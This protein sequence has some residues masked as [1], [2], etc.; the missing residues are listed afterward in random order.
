MVPPVSAR[1]SAFSITAPTESSTYA[2]A[3]A[4]IANEM[5]SLAATQ[6]YRISPQRVV[7]PSAIPVSVVAKLAHG[8]TVISK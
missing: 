2:K 5:I 4:R 7:S 8:S 6:R 1:C 3:E